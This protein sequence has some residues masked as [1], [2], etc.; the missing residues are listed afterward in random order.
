MS[1]AEITTLAASTPTDCGATPA[2]TSALAEISPNDVATSSTGNSFSYDIAVTIGAGDTG[3]DLVAITVPGTFTVPASPVTDVQVDGSPVAFTDNTSGNDISVDL[4]SEVTT[5][6]K[7]TVFFDADAPASQDLIGKDF[8]SSVDDSTTG[9]AAQSTTEGNG[10]GDGSDNDSWLVTTTDAAAGS[11][12]VAD[13]AAS[14]GTTVGGTSMTISHTTS[15]TDRLML[16]GV[17]FG[18]GSGETVSEVR[19]NGDLLNFEGARNGPGNDSRIE[20]WS[21]LAPDTGTHNVVVTLSAGSHDGATAGVMTFTEV[22]QATPLGTFASNAGDSTSASTTVS[23]AVG[24]LVFGV[25]AVDDTINRDLVPGAGQ[26]PERWDIHA[27][28][29]N[30]GGSTEEGAPSVVTSWSW[31]PVADDWAVGGISIKPAVSCSTSTISGTVY[32]DVNYGGGVGRDL[33]SAN[34]DAPAFTI[35]RDGVTV[36]L[37]DAAGSYISNTTTAGGGLYSFAALTPANYTV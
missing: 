17:S 7:I 21:R 25:L 2:V 30:G 20:I 1:A 15:G 35:E 6:G 9:E 28:S 29:A 36:E 33:A 18:L 14:T 11:C 26:S 5:S 12:V 22:D 3:V 4:T 31:S 32:E 8:L 34:A 37:Y 19:Y 24:E 10:D 16:V 13:G 23:S 27:D